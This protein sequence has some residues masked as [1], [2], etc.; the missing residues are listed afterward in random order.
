MPE[1]RQSSNYAQESQVYLLEDALELWAAILVQTPCSAA[2]DVL[3]LAP[4][5]FSVFELGTEHLRK[6]LQIMESYIILAP[7]EML[8]DEMRNRLLAA[9]T[10]LLGNL[11]P[12]SNGMITHLVE[13]IIREADLLGGQEGVSVIAQGLV[14]TGFLTNVIDGLRGSWEAH[15]TTGPN[16]KASK[17][18]GIVETDY[19]SVIARLTL[20]TP[21]GFIATLQAIEL[22]RGETI[23]QTMN[24]LLTEWFSHFGNIGH[25]TQRKL[26]CL[27]LTSLL[28][29]GAAWI[30]G[31]LQEL[32][33]VWTDVVTEVREGVESEDG[34]YV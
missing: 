33:T 22:S 21:R 9:L 14:A 19:F 5:L 26:G 13:L 6:A 24:W 25:P 30:L 7:A 11:K 10:S 3:F 2:S 23:E 4:Y 27:A 15:Q 8:N 1:I 29:T 12:E 31:K 34:E 32:M 16:K 18:D 20:P 17:V 28:E